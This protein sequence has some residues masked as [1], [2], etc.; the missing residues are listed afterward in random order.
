[1]APPS[2]RLRNHARE[3][4]FLSK[5][6]PK[7]RKA[8]LQHADPQLIK[9][10]CECAANVVKGNVPLSRVQKSKLSRYKKHLRELSNKRLSNKKR[11]D[12]LIQRG[13]FLSLILK[14]IIQSLGGMLLG[15]VTQR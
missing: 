3:I 8:F 14:P 1:M 9:S 7:Q 13:G 4:D 2:C 10:L 6:S 11:K 15:A 12:I 5:C